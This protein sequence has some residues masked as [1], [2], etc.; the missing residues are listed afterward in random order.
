MTG[1]RRAFACLVALAALVSSPLQACAEEPPA[2]SPHG[3]YSTSG[4]C[5]VCHADVSG[6]YDLVRADYADDACLYCHVESTHSGTPVYDAGAD[7][8]MAPS[9]HTVGA[10]P[11]IPGSSASQRA[12]TVWLESVDSHGRA[13]RSAIVVRRYDPEPAR[14]YRLVPAED[15]DGWLR[16]GPV[17]L[18]CVNCHEPHGNSRM[19][20]QPG[21]GSSD[22]T[23]YKLL[24]RHP[25][26]AVGQAPRA[27]GTYESE[28]AVSA[29][30]DTARAGVNFSS[31]QSFDGTYTADGDV[32][33]RPRWVVQDF[34]P[35]RARVDTATLSWWCA[36]CHDLMLGGAQEAPSELGGKVHAERTHPCPLPDTGGG[37]GQCYTCHRSGLAPASSDDAC[38]RCHYGSE[39]YA[40]DRSSSEEVRSDFPHSGSPGDLTLLG[41]FA[42]DDPEGSTWK[43]V[44]LDESSLDSVC[45]R[46]HSGIGH[47]Q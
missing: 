4:R 32:T 11:E 15:G 22:E 44:A 18:R 2:A 34:A 47:T 30:A 6:G 27:N 20:W 16:V 45:M 26:G 3:G 1:K 8:I 46:C 23:G 10:P 5:D 29:I 39:D 31:V 13:T 36:D 24:R 25:S 43:T 7:G 33:T 37:P 17:P 41:A 28:A 38:V 40:A 21:E 14:M 19:L 9:G 12:E 42:F 35:D